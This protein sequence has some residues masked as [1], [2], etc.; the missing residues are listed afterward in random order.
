M[1]K[2]HNIDCIEG[3]KQLEDN[4]IDLLVTD[5][6]YGYSFM[7]KDWDEAVP[8]IDVWK[9]CIRVLKDGA[10]AF[11]MSSPRSDVQCEMVTRI[12]DAG[13]R[14]D[15][16]PIYWTYASGFPKAMNIGKM[17]DKK[18]G[19][20]REIIGRNPNSREN[21][22]KNNTI[23]ESGTVGKTAY[24]DKGNSHLEGSYAGF[25]PKPA[26]EVII[27]AMKPLSESTY[28]EQAIKNQKG[29]TWLDDCRIPI[30]EKVDDP[31]LGGEGSWI[32]TKEQSIYGGGKGIPRGEVKSNIFGRFPSNLLVSDDVLGSV[33]SDGASAPVMRGQKGFGG[34]IYGIFKMG[35][36]DGK[37]F[38]SDIEESK[39]FSRYFDLDKWSQTYP[40]II[41]PKASKSEKNRGLVDDNKHP[42]V[43]PIELMRYLIVLG[44]RPGDIVLDPFIG[45]GTT[46][47]A[48]RMLNRKYIGFEI[49]K[50]YCDIANR[51][52]SG[53]S[54]SQENLDEL[55]GNVFE[56]WTN[57][58]KDKENR[59]KRND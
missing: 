55:W 48:A 17:Y 38:Y 21:C 24:I 49:S 23:Y 16:T 2:I 47:I 26:V 3:M 7:D 36:D 44:S 18:M 53:W 27:V 15:F 41:I 58:E 30:N 40:F 12:R 43:K 59:R 14:V 57:D 50:E 19:N 6:P 8:S 20:D 9:E 1:N 39:S 35:G 11:I 31:R 10:F 5:P 4:S 54:I 45:T 28:L 33:V 51:R 13:F 32:T 29:I 52:M 42:T 22:D 46:G 34:E 25:Q 37:T 56:R